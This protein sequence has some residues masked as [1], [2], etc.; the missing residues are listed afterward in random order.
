MSHTERL[1]N[2]GVCLPMTANNLIVLWRED[3][4]RCELH[5][6]TPGAC[7]LLVYREDVVVCAEAIVL[8]HTAHVR[9]EV[10]RRRVLRGNRSVPLMRDGEPPNVT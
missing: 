8:G 4:W 3:D 10:L 5:S 2:A 6:G 1:K 7:C 9:A